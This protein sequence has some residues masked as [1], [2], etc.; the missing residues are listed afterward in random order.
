MKLI[1]EFG[2]RTLSQFKKT[3]SLSW[4][5][6]V[7]HPRHVLVGILIVIWA[8]GWFYKMQSKPSSQSPPTRIN[9][10]YGYSWGLNEETLKNRVEERHGDTVTLS[11][12]SIALEETVPGKKLTLKQQRILG[13]PVTIEFMFGPQDDFIKGT[14]TFVLE[15]YDSCRE[16]Y[17]RIETLISGRYGIKPDVRRSRNFTE[18]PFCEALKLGQAVGISQWEDPQNQG[19]VTM[20]LG[21]L[22]NDKIRVIVESDQYYQYV[23]TKG[24]LPDGYLPDFL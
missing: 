3:I 13:V 2:R 15:D 9:S 6:I 16:L 24:F 8:M 10:F 17:G 7:D 4:T 1:I 19:L 14:F 18:K 22:S 5:F 23:E 21:I 12:E 20:T 11:R